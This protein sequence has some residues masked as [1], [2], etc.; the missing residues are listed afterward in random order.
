MAEPTRSN[1]YVKIG[2]T[3]VHQAF[4]SCRLMPRKRKLE[5]CRTCAEPDFSR[6][7]ATV[8]TSLAFILL[9]LRLAFNTNASS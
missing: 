5:S 4:Q 8:L 7:M 2:K 9:S 1:A 6:Q 3:T